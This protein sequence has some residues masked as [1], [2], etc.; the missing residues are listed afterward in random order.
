VVQDMVVETLH[1]DAQSVDT[2]IL[3]SIEMIPGD[4]VGIGF[5]GN[6]PKMKVLRDFTEQLHQQVHAD[7]RSAAADI[8][9][10]KFKSMFS[11]EVDFIVQSLKIGFRRRGTVFTPVERTVRAQGITKRDVN[12]KKVIVLSR[13]SGE[14]KDF[15][16]NGPGPQEN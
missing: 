16:G 1:T 4:V 11:V 5:H 2:S 15:F 9:R 13:G 6:F 14:L 10:G 8:C 12:V 7:G 3:Q